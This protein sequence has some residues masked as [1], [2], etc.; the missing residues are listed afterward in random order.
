VN[1]AR[2]D[3]RKA[4]IHCHSFHSRRDRPQMDLHCVLLEE[5]HHNRRRPGGER[6]VG[7]GRNGSER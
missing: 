4:A 5:S 7:K 2:F 1:S 3:D 6:D